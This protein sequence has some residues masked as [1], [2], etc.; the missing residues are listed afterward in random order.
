MRGRRAGRS[1]GPG[2]Q[3]DTTQLLLRP[4]LASHV[5]VHAPVEDGSPWIVQS[6]QAKYMRV[7]ADMGRLLTVL[8][9]A[10]DRRALVET[11]GPPWNE[12]VLDGVVGKLN[13]QGL[14]D[15]GTEHRQS[16]TWFKWVPPMTL[17]FT[18]IKPHWLLSRLTPVIRLLANK[19]GAALG[20]LILAGGLLSLLLQAPAL[21]T[22]LGEPVSFTVLLAVFAATLATTA[23][24]EMGHGAV[25]THYGGRPS[26]MGFMLFYLSPAF[27]CD[28][29]DGWRLPRK[30]QRTH[31]ALAGI[32]TQLVIGMGA[33]ITAL[34]VGGPSG[35]SALHTGLL[36]FAVSTSVTGLL[37]FVPFVKLDGYLALMS[38]FDVSHLRDHAMTD[39]RRWVAGV[40]FGGRYTRELPQL[41]W[42][43][44]F[45]LACMVFPLYL[46]GVA[47]TLW[48]DVFTGL[49]ITGAIILGC[50][51]CYLLYRAGLGCKKLVQEARSAGAGF[52]RITVV[53]VLAAGALT[54]ALTLIQIPY[55]VTGGFVQ[56][57]GRVDLV[58][59]DSGDIDA[60]HKGSRVELVK[61]GMIL[62]KDLATTTL[63]E[64][65]P[66]QGEAPLSAFLP[67]KEGSRYPVPAARIPLG[68]V[69]ALP[70][71][72]KVGMAQID[73]GERPLGQWLYLKYVAPSLR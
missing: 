72:V 32:A 5:Q 54:A 60:V 52:G 50:G 29:S 3:R 66:R 73:A 44:P 37:N 35:E 19:A 47:A 7:G 13:A 42:S 22:A 17:Q 70:P 71:S 21:T 43:V 56:K 15:D 11:L 40:L 67:V 51:L 39:A 10:R 16:G 64:V 2:T 63:G 6:G 27:F 20:I 57:D 53:G 28:V 59:A 25:L 41:S 46:V 23:L 33:A 62:R 49:G 4:R 69:D 24:H 18:V 58:I 48:T 31:V 38:H 34:A 68:T 9:G 61:R 8:D 1:T 26:R 45:G 55:T 65:R 14:L 30:E 36:V 12:A